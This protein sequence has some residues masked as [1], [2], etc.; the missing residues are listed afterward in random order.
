M[1]TLRL[2]LTAA[3]LTSCDFD[4][5]NLNAPGIESLQNPTPSQVEALA[6]GLLINARRGYTE[7]VGAVSEWGVLGRE[8]L[9]LTS[10]EPRF[11]SQLLQGPLSAG[12]A[13]FGGNFWVLPYANIRGANLLLHALDNPALVAMTDAQKEAMRGF[14][15]TI[16]ALDYLQV[17][18]AHDVNGV[19]LDVDHDLGATPAP[20]V[21]SL[22]QIYTSI[23]ALL[24]DARTHLLAGGAA[25]PF[26]LGSGFAGFDT[27]ATFLPFNR[28]LRARV[29]VYHGKFSDALTALSESFL[30][31]GQPL[32]LGVYHAFGAG[33]GDLPN[34]LNDTSIF[35]HDS[36]VTDA[37]AQPG[38]GNGCNGTPPLPLNCLDQR[39]QNKVKAVDNS[40][41][42]NHSSSY[43]FTIYP[44]STSPIPIIRNEELILLRAEAN[45]GLG[46][47]GNG[48]GGAPGALRDINFIRTQSGGLDPVGP[49]AD[50]SAALDE[51][52][53]QKR[54][55][56]LFEGGHRWIDLRRY[57]KLDFTHL[58]Q[59]NAADLINAA[60]P[61]P[62]TET[63]ARP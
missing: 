63:E 41:L 5:P 61:I 60:F 55:S 45:I 27:P 25:F 31:K 42:S 34:D 17:V 22:D 21:T 6:V 54:Y 53:N 59:D 29:A 52:L 32:T 48:T 56:L 9:V 50:A 57:G 47:L 40:T 43:A 1:K 24:D 44:N 13:N 30:D 3:L 18:D 38:G 4:V 37:E 46:N 16:Q 12:D 8:S 15:K 39:V 33:S 58:A 49:F 14:A 28:A 20:I 35:C 36:V 7:R 19:V 62:L 10:S 11:I 26:Q 2:I 51:L 23:E